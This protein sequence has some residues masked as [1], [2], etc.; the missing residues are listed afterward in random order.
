MC[1]LRV[2]A[3]WLCVFR[4]AYCHTLYTHN[5]Q[6]TASSSSSSSSYVQTVFSIDWFWG[7]G[8]NSEPAL[9]CAACQN[10]LLLLLASASATYSIT[11]DGIDHGTSGFAHMRTFFEIKIYS[12]ITAIHLLCSNK[13]TN[14]RAHAHKIFVCC[15]FTLSIDSITQKQNCW[16]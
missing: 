16:T 6:Y 4:C 2:C 7:S 12:R 13:L 8:L 1:T 15:S 3:C 10:L 9:L 11:V 5:T 14:T